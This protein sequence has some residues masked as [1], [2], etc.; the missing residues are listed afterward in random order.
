MF[1]LITGEV[2]HG[3]EMKRLTLQDWQ[4]KIKIIKN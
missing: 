3:D 2:L 1:K 4:E